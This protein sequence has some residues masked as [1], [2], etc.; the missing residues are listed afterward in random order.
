MVT[1]SS[2]TR[3][4]LIPMNSSTA[5][6]ALPE[7]AQPPITVVHATASRSGISWPKNR[8]AASSSP[9]RTYAASMQFQAATDFPSI[10]SNTFRASTSWRAAAY[11][12]MRLVITCPFS[13][14]GART[15]LASARAWSARPWVS[16]PAPAEASAARRVE[17]E[18][19]LGRSPWRPTRREKSASNADGVAPDPAAARRSRL[20][21]VGGAGPCGEAERK[22]SSARGSGGEGEELGEEE[23]LVG[24][25]VEEELG[26]ELVEAAAGGG[27]GGRGGARAAAE[28]LRD[29]VEALLERARV[30]DVRGKVG[31]EEGDGSAARGIAWHVSP[32]AWAPGCFWP[33]G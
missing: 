1:A 25:A 21:R 9:H 33:G 12:S 28:V 15:P 17:K 23:A 18:N 4:F 32:A 10:S 29:E 5:S 11:T 6:A 16:T 20:A 27:R 7:F 22:M 24:E 14:D 8:R 13:P 19:A 26:V 31:W 30:R 3:A 2:L